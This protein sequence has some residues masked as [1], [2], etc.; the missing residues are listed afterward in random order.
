MARCPSIQ[1]KLEKLKLESKNFCAMPS[2]TFVYEVD[3]KR[4]RHVVDLVG[5]TC[6]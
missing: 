3:N 4:E 1:D 6:S 2:G 5:K